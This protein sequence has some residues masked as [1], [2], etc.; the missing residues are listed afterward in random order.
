V[1]G[2]FALPA[3]A[4]EPANQACVGKSLSALAGPGFG[5][6]IVSFAQG[7]PFPGLGGG[8]QLLQAGA[9][10]DEVVPNICNN[11]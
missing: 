6:G 11:P 4:A 1:S 9:I 5:Q 7:G 8:M 3:D 10:P 2:L